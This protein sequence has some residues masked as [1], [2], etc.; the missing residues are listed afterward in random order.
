MPLA[1]RR[2]KEAECLLTVQKAE[3]FEVRSNKRAAVFQRH[4]DKKEHY[5]AKVPHDKEEE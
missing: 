2:I 4:I 3:S 1:N 5:P